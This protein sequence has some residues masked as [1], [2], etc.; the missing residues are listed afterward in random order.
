[1]ATLFQQHLTSDGL[2]VKCLEFA[3]TL[4][5]VMDFT[6]LRAL[7]SLCSM[8]NQSCRNLLQYNAQHPDFPLTPDQLESYVPRSLV[9]AL[10]W[11][12]AGDGKLK[13]RDQLG[14]FIRGSTTIR[15]RQE[16]AAS[17]T[18]R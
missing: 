14:E 8:L 4:E 17:S 18:R 16:R 7:S 5:H 9:H 11:S 2:V 15:C 1:M 12:F 10:L 13:T 3:R 6:R